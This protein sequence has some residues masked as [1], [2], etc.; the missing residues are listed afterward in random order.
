MLYLKILTHYSSLFLNNDFGFRDM[1]IQELRKSPCKELIK[2]ADLMFRGLEQS[3]YHK[4]GKL[5]TRT[6]LINIR[7]KKL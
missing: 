1:A 7:T 5:G 6:Q 3:S 4:R 2:L